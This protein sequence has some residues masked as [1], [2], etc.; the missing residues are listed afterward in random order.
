[1]IFSHNKS[2]AWCSVI[3]TSIVASLVVNAGHIYLTYQITFAM[4]LALHPGFTFSNL[5]I[6]TLELG[7]KYVQS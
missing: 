2:T 3:L 4:T 6:E 1:M 7:V 5:K